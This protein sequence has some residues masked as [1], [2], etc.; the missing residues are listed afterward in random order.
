MDFN[1][2]KEMVKNEVR[3]DEAH[4]D[5]T[6]IKIPTLHTKYLG[7]LQESQARLVMLKRQ[8]DKK[9]RERWLYYRQDFNVELKSKAE[10]ESL[11]LGED[12]FD[13]LIFQLEYEKERCEYL[14][15]VIKQIGS[16]GY[17]VRDAIEWRKFE[18]GAY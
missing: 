15:S 5:K 16:L 14:E 12:E 10:Y 2:L 17:L 18:A 4:L 1:E 6:A 3:I 13:S 7:L 11:I 9:Y 8:Y